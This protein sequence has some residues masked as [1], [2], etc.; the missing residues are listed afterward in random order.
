MMLY[1][2]HGTTLS[3]AHWH[4]GVPIPE[5]TVWIDMNHPSPEQEKAVEDFM[6]IDVPT[7]EE[8]SAIE[9]SERLYQDAGAYFMTATVITKLDTKEPE[10][11]PV[12][13][14]LTPKRLVTVRYSDP[15][16]FRVFA[17]QIARVVPAD[18]NGPGL[19]LELMD[20][21]TNRAADVLE[22]IALELDTLTREV[23]DKHCLAP[24]ARRVDHRTALTRIGLEGDALSKV[25]ESMTSFGRLVAFSTQCGLL[26]TG[27]NRER[28]TAQAADIAGLNDQA[29]YLSNKVTFLLDAVLG[30]VSIEQNAIIKIFSVAATM[31]LPPTL[32]ASIYG[33]NFEFMPELHAA[34]GYPLAL[35]AMVLSAALP[36]FYFKRKKW[37]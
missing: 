17:S 21:I 32:I 1:T 4:A 13:F 22:R 27:E 14:I 25:R 6:G 5:D 3:G 28:L 34:Y 7:R 2:T 10:A 24:G 26:N 12:T 8:M 18:Q 36:Y 37:L 16:P 11:H 33:M 19:F 23:F 9:V 15:V 30:M 35:G 20:A 31:F 29:N